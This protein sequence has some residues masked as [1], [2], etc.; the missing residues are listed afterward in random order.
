MQGEGI[1]GKWVPFLG[2]KKNLTK[3]GKNGIL[4]RIKN[5]GH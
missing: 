1:H 3:N 5:G 2:G 4:L